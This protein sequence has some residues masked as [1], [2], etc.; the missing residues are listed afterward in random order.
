MYSSQS[1]ENNIVSSFNYDN[2]A[3]KEINGIKAIFVKL[4]LD[5]GGIVKQIADNLQNKYPDCL[6]FIM[7]VATDKLLFVAKANKEINNKGIMCGNLVKQAALLCGG[8]GG[9]RP[10]FAQAG[11]KDV[12]KAAEVFT[13]AEG[14]IK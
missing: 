9:G 6:I 12:S 11:G 8:N 10:D 3:I 2:V 13:L 14:L 4:E 1:F 7:S 5:D